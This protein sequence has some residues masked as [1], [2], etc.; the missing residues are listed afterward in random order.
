MPVIRCRN[1]KAHASVSGIGD[2]VLLFDKNNIFVKCNRCKT[3][4]KINITIPGIDLD[5]NNAAF[6]QEEIKRFPR[7]AI[8]KSS[9]VYNK[10][11]DIEMYGTKKMPV[12][13]KEKSDA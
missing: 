4:W 7:L 8:D 12:I 3:H 9:P 1:K 5:L 10:N 6:I 13:I 11:Y 2:I